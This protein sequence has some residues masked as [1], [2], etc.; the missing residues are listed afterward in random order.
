MNQLQF[1]GANGF[2][3]IQGWVSPGHLAFVDLIAE[4]QDAAGITGHVAE[5]GVYH[6]NSFWL[7]RACFSRAG[8][9]RRSM[10][11]TIKTR[12]WTGRAS[13]IRTS[14]SATWRLTAGGIWTTLTYRL[15]AAR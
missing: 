1:Y 12:I 4:T 13:E 9:L 10:S 3:N 2:P 6:G 5:I 7:W 14:L 8:R 15:T 11:S